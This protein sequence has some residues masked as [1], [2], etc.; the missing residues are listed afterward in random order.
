MKN[1]LAIIILL[2]FFVCLPFAKI[3]ELMASILDKYLGETKVYKSSVDVAA[4][5][6]DWKCRV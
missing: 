6:I 5:M 4:R 3:M 2:I 1:I